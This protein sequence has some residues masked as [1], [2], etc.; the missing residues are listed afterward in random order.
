M[1]EN[2]SVRGSQVLSLRNAVFLFIWREGQLWG[3]GSEYYYSSQLCFNNTPALHHSLLYLSLPPEYLFSR[4]QNR[5]AYIMLL[6]FPW[7]VCA[8]A[9]CWSSCVQHI[10]GEWNRL[11]LHQWSWLEVYCKH[12]NTPG[13]VR[14]QKPLEAATW[15]QA[16]SSGSLAVYQPLQPAHCETSLLPPGGHTLNTL[17]HVPWPAGYWN[18]EVKWL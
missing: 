14:L 13:A 17:L 7:G 3:E 10:S 11:F 8:R 4:N 5:H 1:V 16:A 6:G 12:C 18:S 2:I 15:Q 9:M